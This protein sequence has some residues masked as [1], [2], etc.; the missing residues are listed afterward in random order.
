MDEKLK[1]LVASAETH[2]GLAKGSIFE[3][4]R[5]KENV[6]AR[7]AVWGILRENKISWKEIT[8]GLHRTSVIHGNNEALKLMETHREF[9]DAFL[10]IKSDYE[11]FNNA[12]SWVI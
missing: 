2:F 5:K 4:T 3:K 7:Y 9:R 8:F 6:F 11:T 10:K 12:Y 1:Y